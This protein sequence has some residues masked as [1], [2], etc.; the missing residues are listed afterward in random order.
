MTLA[1]AVNAGWPSIP[2][3][4]REGRRRLLRSPRYPD[5][6]NL[7]PRRFVTITDNWLTN[8]CLRNKKWTNRW[9]TTGLNDSELFS[10]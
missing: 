6:N 5:T 8:P 10:L 3:Q 4:L 7:Q 1:H 2:Q 9:Q